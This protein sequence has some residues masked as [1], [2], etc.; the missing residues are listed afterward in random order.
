MVVLQGQALL[1]QERRA[2]IHLRQPGYGLIVPDKS[3]R[4]WP[5]PNWGR[6]SNTLFRGTIG[7]S[8]LSSLSPLLEGV[9]SLR[10]LGRVNARGTL[11]EQDFP[12]LW[13]SRRVRGRGREVIRA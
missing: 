12:V 2:S 4:T 11:S 9:L 1:H 5:H 13:H 8:E 10:K 7:T 6:E 3:M